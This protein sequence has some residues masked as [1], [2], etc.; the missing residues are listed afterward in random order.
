ML[1]QILRFSCNLFLVCLLPASSLWAASPLVT[2]MDTK[3]GSTPVA[4]L[5]VDTTMLS[6]MFGSTGVPAEFSLSLPYEGRFSVVLKS[7]SV[8]E[9]SLV[10]R[11]RKGAEWVSYGRPMVAAFKGSI[12]GLDGSKVMLAITNDLLVGYIEVS[13]NN[14]YDRWIIGSHPDPSVSSSVL[15]HDKDAIAPSPWLCYANDSVLQGSFQEGSRKEQDRE[16][17]TVRRIELAIECDYDMYR[18]HNSNVSRTA[19]Y[20]IAVIAATSDIYQREANSAIRI[21]LLDVWDQNDPYTG[22]NSS[23]LLGEFRNY[24]RSNKSSVTRTLAMLLSGVNG[25]GGV[26]YLN[27]LCSKNW[28]YSVV[29]LNNNVTYPVSGYVWDTDVTAHELGHNVGSPHT[30]SCNWTPPIDS[31]YT[32]EGNCFTGTKAVKGTIMSYCHLTNQGKKLEFHSRVQTV[33]KSYLESA[34]CVASVSVP[35]VSFEGKPSICRGQSVKL[36]PNVSSARV[37]LSFYWSPATG[38]NDRTIEKP[39]ASPNT[40][41]TYT[42]VV[43]DDNGVT[44]S[45]TVTVKVDESGDVQA[46]NDTTVCNGSMV[47]LKGTAVFCDPNRWSVS[48]KPELPG[49]NTSGLSTTALVFETTTFK[50]TATSTDGLVRSDSLTVFINDLPVI[51]GLATV[52]HCIGQTTVLSPKVVGGTPPYSY[53]WSPGPGVIDALE[54]TVSPLQSETYKIKVTDSNGCIAV[55]SAR[56]NAFLPPVVEAIKDTSVCPSAR[57]LLTAR[58]SAGSGKKEVHWETLDGSVVWSG[59]VMPVEVQGS[60]AYRAICTDSAG[61]S[62]TTTTTVFVRDI[63][64]QILSPISE[65]RFTHCDSSLSAVLA[66][67]NSGQDTAVIDSVWIVGARV[68]VPLPVVLAPGSD[69]SIALVVTPD[70]RTELNKMIWV[71][72]QSCNNAIF[73]SFQADFSPALVLTDSKVE[74]GEILKCDSWQDVDVVIRLSKSSPATIAID[75]ITMNNNG[76]EVIAPIP[77]ILSGSEDTELKLTLLVPPGYTSALGLMNLFV[78]EGT[79][80]FQKELNVSGRFTQAVFSPTDTF[81]VGATQ[82]IDTTALTA[83]LPFVLNTP[84]SLKVT[85]IKVEGPFEVYTSPEV[86]MN[87]GMQ[88]PISVGFSPRDAAGIGVHVGRIILSTELCIDAIDIPLSAR[89]E[90]PTSIS[91]S[92]QD[93]KTMFYHIAESSIMFTGFEPSRQLRLFDMNGRTLKVWQEE[94]LTTGRVPVGDLVSGVYIAVINDRSGIYSVRIPILH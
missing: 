38:L 23:T 63:R 32:A 31:C 15:F 25:I 57:L 92:D 80:S 88:Y 36:E 47:E 84:D 27:T 62:D 28:G 43:R 18:D 48:W 75:S 20:A 85:S 93:A 65:G 58:V 42:V 35:E 77:L 3:I 54:L 89:I 5:Q 30:H 14:R 1:D 60:T 41:T 64:I 37:P 40:T 11:N 26:A 19:N 17:A 13:T 46:G 29:G 44:G 69:T 56:V 52:N 59:S 10:I 33:L 53:E 16:Q 90:N 34:S 4:L 22:T 76:I 78:S 9:P 21:S 61:C 45:A 68:T 94:Q 70:S 86:W 82:S 50:V 7:F 71:R 55:D 72:E 66:L 6:S 51:S 83:I 2:S 39:Q 81:Y 8:Y 79:C 67:R 49:M 87:A 24:W 73:N 74:V 12:R 91:G